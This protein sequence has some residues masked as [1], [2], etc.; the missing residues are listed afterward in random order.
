MHPYLVEKKQE[1]KLNES[2]SVADLENYAQLVSTALDITPRKTFI[3]SEISSSSEEES[4][5][6]KQLETTLYTFDDP[7]KLVWESIKLFNKE[8]IVKEL[9]KSKY[10][11]AGGS[12]GN[13]IRI[14]DC[15][16]AMQGHFLAAPVLRRAS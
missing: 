2:V 11:T 15:Y 4:V 6:K 14:N 9:L 3:E 7:T 5:S 8:G 10:R 12:L 13:Y 16:V 1:F